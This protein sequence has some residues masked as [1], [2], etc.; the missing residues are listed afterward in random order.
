M[1]FEAHRGV[2]AEFP[3][4]T[5]PAF[6]AAFAQGYTYVELDP[7]FTSDGHCVVF[8]DHT[9]NRTCRAADGK[10]LEKETRLCDL[11]YEQT[12]KLD[13]GIA[14][15]YKFRGTK[16]PLLSE[17]LT[18][19]K[20]TG[21]TVKIDNRVQAF[22]E[23]QAASL[24]DTV[25]ASGASVAFTG[26]DTAY[27]ARVLECF[28]DAEIHYD[29][30][31]NE[32]T[33][34]E[35]RALVGQHALTVGL[36]VKSP[37]TA[38]VTVPTAD[39]ALCKTVKRYANL[40]L[41]ILSTSEQLEQAE[42]FQA[43]IIETAG[44]IKPCGCG[45]GLRLFD[46]HTHTHFSHD[47]KCDPHDSLEKARSCGL[48]G[49]AFTDHCDNEFCETE[50][51]KTPI[52]RSADCAH[53]LSAG[54]DVEVLAGVEIGE[55]LWHLQNAD[56]LIA[57]RDFDIVLGSVHAVRYKDKTMPYS[58]ID[59][60]LFSPTEITEFLSVYFADMLEMIQ[61]TDFDVLSH[62]TCPLRYICGKYGFSID[63]AAH[64]AVIDII[65]SEIIRRGIALE[66]NTSCLDSGYDAL[67][68]NADILKRYRQLGGYLIT[69]GSDAHKAERVA[70]GFE[71]TRE[72]LRE[73][74]FRN[75]FHYRKRIPIPQS[76]LS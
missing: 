26:S 30:T 75:I 48:A 67:M 29:G 3:E 63:L 45:C 38:W 58:G 62:L 14:K 64:T 32:T 37:E 12:Q 70:Y 18:W 34:K 28:P 11:S 55:G 44:Q 35:L 54:T 23:K 59:F 20:Q 7:A 15:A 72:I 24:F 42:A 53:M 73:L 66:V 74:G 47:S 61:K 69:V 56:E 51:V 52:F 36:P 27:I 60:S 22:S 8:H 17:V 13:A 57:A 6:E 9:V 41:W 10:A 25:A 49:L 16:I 71:K 2:S 46:C 50:D 33:L 68:P 1:I 65:L 76:I 39:E 31:V 40:G 4:N 5:L 43:D 21:V 19:A